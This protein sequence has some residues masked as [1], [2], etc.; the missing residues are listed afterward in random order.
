MAEGVVSERPR[1]HLSGA[2]SRSVLMLRSRI[3]L[4]AAK[5]LWFHFD[6]CRTKERVWLKSTGELVLFY[7]R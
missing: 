5:T 2:A 6:G 4:S 7:F 3:R 1:T